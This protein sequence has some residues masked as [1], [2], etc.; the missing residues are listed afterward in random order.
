[1][2][3]SDILLKNPN[4]GIFMSKTDKNSHGKVPKITEEEYTAY[5]N[6][7]RALSDEVESQNGNTTTPFNTGENKAE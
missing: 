1:M 6:Q 5:V 2:E 4:G 7:L 3:K